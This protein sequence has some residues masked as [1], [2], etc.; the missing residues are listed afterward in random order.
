VTEEDHRDHR[1]LVLAPTGRDAELAIS[2]LAHAG[3]AAEA[4]T[5]LAELA[6]KA[7][8]G[9]G[10][11]LVAEEA[12]GPPAVWMLVDVL[13][14]QPPWS[15]LPLLILT[16]G[17]DTTQASLSAIRLVEP[18]GNVTLLERP[19]RVMTL[20]SSVH[21][22]LRARRRQYEVRDHLAAR[23][24][25]EA[26]A[27]RLLVSERVARAEVEAANRAK[28]EFLAIL[29]HELRTPLQ[30]ILGWVKLL[31]S[32]RLDHDTV[33]RALT[34]VERNVRAQ[35]Q[36]VEDL[37]D[38][39]RIVTGKLAVER[40]P[41][42][43]VP[44]IEAA[45]EAV[46]AMADPRGV[47]IATDLDPAATVEGDANRLQQVVWNLLSNAVA[48]SP[49][50]GRVDV[51]LGRDDG[52]AVLTV[53]DRGRGIAAELLPFVFDRFRQGDS[54]S[55]RRHGGLGL[56]LAI[57]RHL[58]ERHRGEVFA[59]SAGE[60]EGATYTV[61]LPLLARPPAAT[62]GA[63]KA[64][65]A[66]GDEGVRLAGLRVLVVDDERDTADLVATALGHYGA[67][68]RVA[69]AAHEALALLE[70]FAPHV[71]VSDVAMPGEDGYSLV[72]RVRAREQIG[73]PRVRA[74]ALTAFARPVDT[75]AAYRAGFEA[76]LAKPVEPAE[77]ALAI[78][79]L[80]EAGE[81]SNGR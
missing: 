63:E 9:A 34:I 69:G 43:L 7:H 44:V 31:R 28:D 15:D 46:K 51:R 55:I 12:L 30:P 72:R 41:L 14:R 81:A 65:V 74:L 61:R 64:R 56:G 42:G 38:V 62:A 52:H 3:L 76:H 11:A 48:F 50:G 17:G 26:E 80:T 39:S 32:Q 23:Q 8:L 71:L 40:R 66:A 13:G 22:A 6:Q 16:S 10:A 47:R 24:R 78:A 19:V 79:R 54:T 35:A 53:Q 57:V 1:V 49:D 37:L 20:L 29:S 73:G 36:I 70:G 68:V 59:H 45:V 4:C 21:A 27:E 25:V 2:M 58:V 18:I 77:L 33:D 67:D 5:T 60:G 75:E